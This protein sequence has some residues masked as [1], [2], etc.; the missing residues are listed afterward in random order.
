ME[1]NWFVALIVLIVGGFHGL[2]YSR[3]F[4]GA[5]RIAPLLMHRWASR[6]FGA[7]S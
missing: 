5:I 2:W 7:S 3:S 1:G 4:D 6:F